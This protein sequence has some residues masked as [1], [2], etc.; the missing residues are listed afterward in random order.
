[1]MAWVILLLPVG[2]E[3]AHM[4][5]LPH[6]LALLK[7]ETIRLPPLVGPVEVDTVRRPHNLALLP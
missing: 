5:K 3:L 7:V 4:A 6:K 2:Q 1:M